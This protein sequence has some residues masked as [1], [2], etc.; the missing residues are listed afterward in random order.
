MKPSP[1]IRLLS[2]AALG[3][4]VSI[5]V[6]A[7]QAA[8]TV[9]YIAPEKFA[10]MPFSHFDKERVQKALTEHLEQLG[11][12]LPA[13]QNLKVDITDI[14]L[15]GEPQPG[16]HRASDFRV[17]RGGADWPR[18]ELRYTIESQGSVVKN[19]EA[20][21][22]DMNYLRSFNRYSS[23][24]YLRYEKRMLDEWFKNQVMKETVSAAR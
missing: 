14:D 17:L 18:I 5:G 15:A 12:K 4:F 23:N 3:A 10:D 22:S 7:V 6:V 1:I 21:L 8:T 13:G 19:G 11:A 24:E 16:A 2:R 9:N 20:K